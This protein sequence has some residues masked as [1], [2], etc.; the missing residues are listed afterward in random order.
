M[1]VV[2]LSLLLLL[3]TE[4]QA[5]GF[6]NH[7]QRQR[8][9]LSL[10]SSNKNNNDD[11]GATTTIDKRRP[12][13]STNED[14]LKEET[15]GG[16]TV[17]QRLREEVESPFRKVRLVLFGSSAGSALTALYFSALNTIKAISGGFADAPPL[18]DAL[19][20]DAINLSAAIV[21]G[22]LAY[23]EYQV[24]EANLQR[25][26]RGG[27]LATLVV[28]P[29]YEETIGVGGNNA[30][31]RVTLSQ[32]RRTSRLVIA[33]GGK[34]YIKSLALSLTSDQ[35]SD[36]NILP[37]KLQET[38][39]IVIPVLLDES[40]MNVVDTKDYWYNDISVDEDTDSEFEKKEKNRNFDITRA[41]N[42]LAFPRGTTL[43]TQYLSEDINTAQ[44][45]QGYDVLKKGI[46]LVVKKNGKILRRATGL[47]P[48]MDIINTMDV[49][50]GKF[51]MPGDTE[52]YG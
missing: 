37:E 10:L 35:L 27:Q 3:V 40:N 33:A 5:Y 39:V 2:A 42:I 25:I 16:Y 19:T 34:D 4:Q 48:W 26:A 18:E 8:H 52:K 20:S 46:T 6:V 22:F 13:P 32:Y 45:K 51:G 17:K 36:T 50:D 43:W 31:K 12:P 24:G 28:E 21:C 9:S 47:P 15:F 44:N 14:F 41:N 29:A 49:L 7:Q 1:R 30:A 23:R 11:T 38:D